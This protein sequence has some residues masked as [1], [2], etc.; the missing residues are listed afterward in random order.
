VEFHRSKGGLGIHAMV[1]IAFTLIT[2]AAILY[3]WTNGL[4]VETQSITTN[5]N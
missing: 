2:V 3:V 5:L 4:P 1:G